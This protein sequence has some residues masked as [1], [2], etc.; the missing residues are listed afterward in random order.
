[1]FKNLL[2]LNKT[3][4]FS[5]SNL[6]NYKV[7]LGLAVLLILSILINFNARVYEK[8]IWLDN[9]TFFTAEGRPLVRQGDP[10]YF[11]NIAMYLKKNIPIE[12]YYNKLNFPNKTK[13]AYAPLLSS[14]IAYLAKDSSLEE[15]IKTGNNLVLISS[16]LTTIGIFVLFYVIGRPF[17][18]LL[19]SL[20]AGISYA[21]FSRSSYGYID[22]DI[23]NLFFMYFLFAIIYLASKKQAWFKSILFVILAGLIGKIFYLWY[24]KPELIILSFLSLV[25]F[26]SINTSDWK[27]ISTNCLIYI[28]LT[29]PI[30]YYDSLSIFLNNPYLNGYLSSNVQSIDLVNSSSLNFNNIFRFIGEQQK[31]SLIEMFQVEGSIYFGIACFA[32]LAIWGI[33]YPLIF[34]G[35]APL[36][37]FFLLSIILGQRAIFYSLPFMWFGFGY[38]INF[39]I[40]NVI[41]FRNL[42][43]NKY[44]VYFFTSLCLMTFAILITK[45]FTKNVIEPYISSKITEAMIQ[46]KDVVSDQSNSV[47]VAPWTYGYQSVLYN[48]IPIITHPGMPTSPRHYFQARA[49]TS[50]DLM[51]TTK[52]LNYIVNGG[53]E[54]ISEKKINNFISLSKD[55]YNSPVPDTDIYFMLTQQQR[56]WMNPTSAIAY[57]DIEKNEPYTFN[58]TTAYEIFNILE[59]N[60][61]DLDTKSLTTICADKEGSLEKTI[62]VN[63]NLG[64]WDDKPILKK[65]V[66]IAD[67]KVEINHN[68]ENPDASLVFQIVKNLQKNT[69]NLYLMN[70][71]VFRSAYNKLFHMNESENF[72]LVYEDY[73]HVKIY[74]INQ[75]L[76]AQ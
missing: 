67:G 20:G 7:I 63:L 3:L 73:P 27:K 46:M 32:G 21:Y 47:L 75:A 42:E 49:L 5:S 12:E 61:D 70:E 52:I 43:I 68:Y 31:L 72:E 1:M 25:F 66:Q 60:C 19:A 33:T 50:F 41:K 23:L 22:T 53:V 64:T 54:K 45:T 58:E 57:W 69:S 13:K 10:A 29:N 65:V 15:I 16:V 4:S 2:N 6:S 37:L 18:A 62:P 8:N 40:F 24:P 55:L 17:E 26:T 35:L 11:L 44:Y 36:S 30:L 14:L 71:T 59:V 48:D 51:E 9:P 28:L 38:L 34:I 56:K 39:I 76:V 74:K